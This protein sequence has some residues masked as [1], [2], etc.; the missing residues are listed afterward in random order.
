LNT[1]IVLTTENSVLQF[2]SMHSTTGRFF[3]V[4]YLQNAPCI[5]IVCN[6][7]SFSCILNAHNVGLCL[8]FAITYIY[9]KT[10]MYA[11]L[12]I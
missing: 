8:Q 3:A 6:H 1:T 4:I 5:F 11:W 7:E 12:A 2:V 9:N 10:Y